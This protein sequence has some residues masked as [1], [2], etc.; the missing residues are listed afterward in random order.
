MDVREILAMC[1]VHLLLKHSFFGNIAVRLKLVEDNSPANPTA[2]TDGL[3]IFYNTEFVKKLVIVKDGKT[4]YNDVRFVVCHELFHVIFDHLPR[5]Q[6]RNHKLANIAADFVDNAT[7]VK[8]RIATLP[9]TVSV[10][11][12]KKYDGL[13]FEEVY[14]LLLKENEDKINELEKMLLDTH[15]EIPED[16]KEEIREKI[17]GMIISAAQASDAASIPEDMQKL[18]ASLTESKMDWRELLTNKMQSQV[19]ADYTYMRPSR[20][21]WDS[22]CI[23]PSRD[24]QDTVSCH[25]AVDLSGSC[26]D[27][28]SDFFS[29]VFGIIQQFDDWKIG[30]FTFDTSVHNYQEFSSE[31]FVDIST[32]NPIGGG[33]TS[34]ECIWKFMKDEEINPKQLVVFTDMEPYGSWGDPNYCETLWIAYK[35]DKIAPFGETVKYQ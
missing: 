26:I 12:D 5:R 28:L 34:F 33:G 32:Y 31:S 2:A 29:E 35:S 13:C 20:K 14:D 16:M 18:I 24:R 19:K 7:I 25:I 22:D 11:Y 15:M 6:K 8:H 21:G 27:A 4:D 9:T 1:R 17:R 23:L 10:L 30:I 3:N